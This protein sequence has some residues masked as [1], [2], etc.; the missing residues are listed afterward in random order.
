[1]EM[2]MSRFL[3]KAYH[4]LTV[5]VSIFFILN[6]SKIHPAYRMSWLKKYRLGFR[7]FLN[8]IRIRTGTSYRAPP[9]DGA[10]DPG[11]A[12]GRCRRRA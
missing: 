5:P 11:D 6:S 3:M 10:Q 12:A 9:G 7:M 4:V 2:R 1:M 8:K